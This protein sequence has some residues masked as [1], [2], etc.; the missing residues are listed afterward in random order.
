MDIGTWIPVYREIAKDLCLSEKED[1]ES[2]RELIEL[3]DNNP[4]IEEGKMVLDRLMELI[5]NR[6]CFIFGGGPSLEKETSDLIC[7]MM[8]GR[9]RGELT[10]IT[11]DGSTSLLYRAGVMPDIIVTDLDGGIEDQIGAVKKGAVM[12]IHGHGD[13]REVIR[14]T[15]GKLGG[16][17]I[18]STQ[19]DP[20]DVPGAVNFGGFTDGDRAVHLAD[21]LGASRIILLGFENENV[22]KKLDDSGN[23]K[24][25]DPRSMN[26]KK[27]K[28]K[29]AAVLLKMVSRIPVQNYKEVGK[30]L[31]D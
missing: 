24:D 15:V 21:S 14:D 4:R 31:F 9:N 28:L 1:L 30:D 20:K 12:V 16:M 11:A 8:E 27:K 3:L 29:W 5:E 13:N 10:L 25:S 26:E 18:G 23:R 2:A 6:T 17:V 7:R 19:L 22:G